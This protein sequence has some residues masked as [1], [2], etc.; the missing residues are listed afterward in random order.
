[1][2]QIND[3]QVVN[4]IKMNARDFWTIAEENAPRFRDFRSKDLEDDI[5]LTG[6]NFTSICVTQFIQLKNNRNFGTMKIQSKEDKENPESEEGGEPKI[7]EI[8]EDD[9]PALESQIV[10][11]NKAIREHPQ[12]ENIKD[13]YLKKLNKERTRDLTRKECW[14][15]IVSELH[16]SKDSGGE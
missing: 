8:E 5:V 3:E 7:P 14:H 11:L 4:L 15:L 16:I 9:K 1:M 13:N 2:A 12:G 6:D 10:T